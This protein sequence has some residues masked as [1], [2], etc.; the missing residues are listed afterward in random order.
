MRVANDYLLQFT[1]CTSDRARD[2]FIHFA[3]RAA[4]VCRELAKTDFEQTLVDALFDTIDRL[5]HDYS[6]WV[7]ER[8]HAHD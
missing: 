3:E 4:H 7:M 8:T 6:K 1:V 5:G 2:I